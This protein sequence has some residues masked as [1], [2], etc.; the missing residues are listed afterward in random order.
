MRKAGIVALLLPLLFTLA[1]PLGASTAQA[2]MDVYVG[3]FLKTDKYQSIGYTATLSSQAG[4]Q[5][6]DENGTQWLNVSDGKPVR[7]SMNGY[8]VL[9]LQTG[10]RAKANTLAQEAEK[11]KLP[12]A[13]LVS[14]VKGVPIYRVTLG[15]YG[16]LAEADAVLRGAA[17]NPALSASAASAVLIGPYYASAGAYGSSAAA[18]AGAAP[19]RDAG[20]HAVEAVTVNGAGAL[21]YRV[22]IGGSPDEMALRKVM[23]DA[24]KAVP[25]SLLT[26][27]DL[28]VPHAVIAADQTGGASVQRYS[29][30]G[31]AVKLTASPNAKTEPIKVDERF[32]RS[33]RGDIQWLVH[34]GVFTVI[35][36]VPLETY[37]AAVVGAELDSSWPEEALKAQ[38]VAARTYVRKQGW[39]HGVAHVVDTTSDQAYRGIER[40]FPAAVDAA[41]ATAGEVL[42]NESG[43][44]M[45]AFY[46]SNAGRMTADPL[47]VWGTTIDGIRPVPSLDD[48]VQRGKLVWYRIARNSGEIVYVRSDFVQVTGDMNAGGFPLGVTTSDSVNVRAAPYVNNETNPAI[49][50]L[51]LGEKVTII[52]REMESTA[53]EWLRGP[54]GADQLHR[55]MIASGV[56]AADVSR[57]NRINSIEV[58]SRGESTGRVTGMSVNGSSINVSRPEQYR[59]LFA[60]P[61]TRFE[62]EETAKVTVLG[63]NGRKTSLPGPG[64]A[65]LYAVGEGGVA[66]LAASDYLITDGS[67]AARVATG[68]PGFRFHGTGN[69]HGLGLS[70]WG[71]FGLAELGY[72]YRDILVYYYNNVTIVKE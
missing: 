53:Y 18:S 35:N 9:L 21:E 13:V 56:A 50:Q 5:V 14:S 69:G 54:A 61:S 41:N 49:A 32:G 16:T 62:V 10:D 27:V 68:T 43:V 46:H 37:V 1:L 26:P 55:Q 4:F 70:Q 23:N 2:A 3:L 63:A 66:A 11:A 59:T 39:K 64:T 47:E 17:G 42:Y 58:T 60:L 12:P 20:F 44:L 6:T 19:Y 67:G 48:R 51:Q 15:P 25:G 22:W 38:A 33:Y 30:G 28:N 52:D 40:E 7:F 36:R 34:N 57:L 24:V 72:D 29:F 45:D 65:A 71:A 31:S 8:G